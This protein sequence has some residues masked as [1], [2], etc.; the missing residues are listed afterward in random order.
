MRN[1]T[2]KFVQ[3]SGRIKTLTFDTSTVVSCVSVNFCL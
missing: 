3:S 1:V 2:A